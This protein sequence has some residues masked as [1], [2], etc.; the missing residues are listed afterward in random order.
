MKDKER[1]G[2]SEASIP[3]EIFAKL[4]PFTDRM[5]EIM[6]W[7][8]DFSH[9]KFHILDALLHLRYFDYECLKQQRI[10]DGMDWE[11]R[12]KYPEWS[13]WW[14]YID[15]PNY[16]R[17]ERALRLHDTGRF[18]VE[19]GILRPDEHHFGSLFMATHI[20]GDPLVCDA[21][22]HHI[23][24]VLPENSSSVA[25]YVR[26]LD[27]IVGAGYIGLIRSAAYYGFEHSLLHEQDEDKVIEDG[28]M[29]GI[30]DRFGRTTEKRAENFFWDN[31]YPYFE[32][33]GKGGILLLG[34]LSKIILDRIYGR[35]YRNLGRG[36]TSFENELLRL[37]NSTLVVESVMPRLRNT[38]EYRTKGTLEVLV[39]TRGGR[40]LSDIYSVLTV[41]EWKSYTS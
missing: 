18:F 15:L 32:S 30:I 31:V 17:I 25:R 39:R 5:D 1:V 9:Q 13:D 23:D 29:M 28:I 27:R 33:Q 36:L 4:K 2:S 6:R 34:T 12:A 26:D 41:D 38:F 40:A 35:D 3:P 8:A 24:D 37:D 22:F 21:V 11:D 14:G 20:D 7:S 10:M 16:D 19:K